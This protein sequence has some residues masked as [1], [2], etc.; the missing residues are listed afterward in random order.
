M[1]AHPVNPV[2]A[3]RLF[4]EAFL[5]LY[6]ADA[7]ADLTRVRSEDAN[8]ANNPSILGHVAE[9]A[10]IFAELAPHALRPH[11]NMGSLD[12]SDASIHRLGGALTREARDRWLTEPAYGTSEG[13]LFNFVVH[14]AA[15]V[16]ECI[17]RRRTERTR[18]RW[19][20]RS[21]LWE[22]LVHLQSAAGEAQLAVF[23]WW[24]KA[25]SDAA[26]GSNASSASLADRYRTH[27]E[28]PT[29]DVD[30]LPV[31]L[32]EDIE[33]KMPR[34]TKVRY[35]ALYKYL[36]AH[37]PEIRDL[38]RDFP[39][40]ERFDDMRLRWLDAHVVGGGRMALLAT[41]GEGG[42]HLFWLDASGFVK[43]AFVAADKFPEPVVQVDGGRVRVVVQQGG[44]PA[45]REMLWWGI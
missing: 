35:D 20:V 14:G 6:P 32:R 42:V 45:M 11:Q 12:F 1:S 27:V 4:R 24:L 13:T 38:G 7:A 21:P 3:E 34:L 16:G 10:A 19:L 33:R 22:S 31:F 15:Y 23:H 9:A 5:P 43:A 18:A 30:A 17:V 28:E 29:L 37:L 25:L 39:S 26:L 2:N 41:A 36:R 40:P 44:E 8:P